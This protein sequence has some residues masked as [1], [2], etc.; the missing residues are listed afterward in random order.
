MRIR[1]TTIKNN[2][3]NSHALFKSPSYNIK[4]YKFIAT[5]SEKKYIV[6]KSQM[7]TKIDLITNISIK[8]MKKDFYILAL[9]VVKT[10][11]ID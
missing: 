7:E 4:T 9:K 11:L 1:T 5:L 3:Y 10:N 2:K 8:I 6:P